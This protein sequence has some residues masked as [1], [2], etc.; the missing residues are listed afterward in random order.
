MSGMKNRFECLIQGLRAAGDD[1]MVFTPD[2]NPPRKYFGA[3]VLIECE[4]G[5]AYHEAWTLA[6]PC[7]CSSSH[8]GCNRLQPKL[9]AVLTQVGI[10][11]KQRFASSLAPCGFS[12]RGCSIESTVLVP[13]AV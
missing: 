12:S 1:V 13:P 3:K 11:C 9:L 8:A 6:S 5:I 7:S 2:R 4:P 10:H